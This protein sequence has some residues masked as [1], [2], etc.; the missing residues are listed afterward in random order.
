MDTYVRVVVRF[1]LVHPDKTKAALHTTSK[2][3]I[4]PVLES[5]ARPVLSYV[6]SVASPYILL[7]FVQ[8]QTDNFECRT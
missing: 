2:F 7:V 5:L 4:R 3:C 6:A 8:H 1:L